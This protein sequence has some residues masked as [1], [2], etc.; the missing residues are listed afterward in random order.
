MITSASGRLMAPFVY[1]FRLSLTVARALF[2]LHP[3]LINIFSLYLDLR[4][5]AAL[6]S[7]VIRLRL[8]RGVRGAPAPTPGSV[9]GSLTVRKRPG[10]IEGQNAGCA[11]YDQWAHPHVR[12][13]WCSFNPVPRLMRVHCPILELQAVANFLGP[14]RFPCNPPSLAR[15]RPA[16]APTP[17][18]CPRKVSRPHTFSPVRTPPPC[19]SL[20]PLPPTAP[21]RSGSEFSRIKTSRSTF[22]I[23]RCITARPAPCTLWMRWLCRSSLARVRPTAP[24]KENRKN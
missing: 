17:D 19:P 10:G 24:A 12:H 2:M 7:A 14:A 13:L 4:S 1:S 16:V 3:L 9:A 18:Y 8:N 21:P 6:D 22:I 23:C 20:P 11:N 5:V 15:R